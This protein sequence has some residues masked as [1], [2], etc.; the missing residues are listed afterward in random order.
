[1]LMHLRIITLLCFG[2]TVLVTTTVASPLPDT[3]RTKQVFPDEFSDLDEGDNGVT[4]SA[5][6][7]AIRERIDMAR[8]WYM[9]ALK[10]LDKKDTVAAA[11]YFERSIE[12]LNELTDEQGIEN[13]F[14]YTRLVHAVVTDYE[15]YVTNIDDL[16]VNSSVFILRDRI[17]AE[18][19]ESKPRVEKLGPEKTQ[20][21]PIRITTTTIPMTMNDEVQNA[22]SFLTESKGRRFMKK[23]LER[24]GRWF[25]TLKKIAEEEGMPPE[26][27]Y[28]AMMESGLNPNAVSKANAVGMWQFIASTGKMYDL[29][30]GSWLDERR[31]VEKATRAAMRFLRDLH[32]DLGDWHLALAAYNA[33][34]GW[35]RRARRRAGLDTGS[36]WEIRHKLPKETRGYVPM[37]IA[38]ATI[39]MNPERFG[40]TPDSLN[41]EKPY[42]YET[43]TVKEAIHLAALA[44][45]A[46]ITVDS[47]RMLNPELRRSTTPP[48]RTYHVKLPVGKKTSFATL[49]AQLTPEQKRPWVEHVVQRRETLSRIAAQ[50]GVSVKELAAVNNITGYRKRIVPGQRLQIPMSEREE[51]VEKPKPVTTTVA[52]T[53]VK[54]GESPTKDTAVT[55]EGTTV[56]TKRTRQKIDSVSLAVIEKDDTAELKRTQKHTVARGENLALIANRYGVSVND[57]RKWNDITSTRGTIV[58]GQELVVNV[59]DRAVTNSRSKKVPVTRI[60]RHKVRR[61]ETLTS[62]AD[63]Y[64][65]S[66]ERIR[67]LNRMSRRYTLKYGT[68]VRVETTTMVTERVA[69]GSVASRLKK[70]ALPQTYKVR[71]GDTLTTIASKFGVSIAQLREANP[72]LRNT[73]IVRV[74]QRIRLQ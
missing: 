71:R 24:T 38:T 11:R 25:P 54:A 46:G 65:T 27:I 53:D 13:N 33:G 67:E 45:C 5:F 35:I 30:V 44:E 34:P 47:M 56:T 9:M 32:D 31:D 43:F 68:S 15:T 7:E 2:L 59:T 18:I 55:D 62:I 37:F 22:I 20:Q 69:E 1:M 39:T 57:L 3:S 23:W 74:G 70:S 60:V 58:V 19:I 49:F 50:Y 73:D 10:Y 12:V 14:Q 63:K 61:G 48:D 4:V 21:S 16:D 66:I 51:E 52:R 72:S 26:I 6:D 36:Y 8:D 28:L 17:F 41:Y 40:F 29:E 64:G 42:K